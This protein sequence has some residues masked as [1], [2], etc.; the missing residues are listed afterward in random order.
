MPPIDVNSRIV[1]LHNGSIIKTQSGSFY[2]LGSI[3]PVFE[4]LYP[5]AKERLIKSLAV[6]DALE[7]DV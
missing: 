3:D 2:E 6:I 4:E 7:Y 1:G 5:G